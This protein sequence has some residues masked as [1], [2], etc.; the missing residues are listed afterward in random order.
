VDDHGLAIGTFGVVDPGFD[1]TVVCLGC[2]ASLVERILDPSRASRAVGRAGEGMLF[3][4]P[5]APVGADETE[6]F[7]VIVRIG[8][9]DLEIDEYPL[10]VRLNAGDVA[11]VVVV[12]PPGWYP[13][14]WSWS[15]WAWSWL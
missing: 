14:G 6:S 8:V 2:T 4:G 1:I 13:S 15:Q 5:A 7:G 9:V 11:V 12:A 10:G 3:L